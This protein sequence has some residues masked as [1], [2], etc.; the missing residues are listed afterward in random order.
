MKALRQTQAPDVSAVY[1]SLQAALGHMFAD[2]ALLATALTH[3]SFGASH[4]ERLEFLGDAVLGLAISEQLYEQ[5]PGFSEG[6]LSRTRANLVRQE[7]LHRIALKL[8]LPQH[9][10]LGLGE[11]KSGGL[12]RPSI[13]ADAVEAIIGAV[14]IDAGFEVA[15]ALVQRLF[16]DVDLKAQASVSARDAKTAL[17]E[18]LQGRRLA[19]PSYAVTHISGL[20]H[21]QVF[22]V[23]CEVP[24]LRLRATGQADS[25]KRAEQAAA[26]AMLDMLVESKGR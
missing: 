8:E 18:H 6:Q 17:Q 11:A 24:A 10:R 20:A 22:H 5:L 21:A 4:N 25:R 16:V 14:C 15:R 7:S 26:Q 12:E 3:R 9:I 19:L 23:S 2:P 1:E 13:L